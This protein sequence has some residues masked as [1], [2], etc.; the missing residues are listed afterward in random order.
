[1]FLVF[2]AAEGRGD[3]LCSKVGGGNTAP[4]AYGDAVTWPEAAL[5]IDVLANDF[6]ADGDAIKVVGVTGVSGGTA[7][8]TS[9][10]AAVAFTPAPGAAQGSFLYTISDTTNRTASAQVQLLPRGAPPRTVSLSERCVGVDCVLT[11]TLSRTDG[12]R[13]ADF[14]FGD[15]TRTPAGY[16]GTAAHHQYPVVGTYDASVTVTYFSGEVAFVAKSINV[17]PVAETANWTWR[18]VNGLRI[19]AKVTST[20]FGANGGNYQYA[21]YFLWGDDFDW[22]TLLV[23]DSFR[24]VVGTEYY[25]VYRGPR[26]YDV[27]LVVFRCS[28]PPCE[29]G[30]A[31]V[32]D[33]PDNP[34]VITP[35]LIE[36][37]NAEPQADF[38]VTSQ[39]GK[40]FLF[41][42]NPLR[43][44]AAA[45]T[46][47]Y[48]EWDFDDGQTVAQSHPV[49]GQQMETVVHEFDRPGTYFV[50]LQLTDPSAST[51]SAQKAVHVP[52][53]PPTPRIAF[54]CDGGLHCSFDASGSTDDGEVESYR[55]EFSDGTS[56]DGAVA[57]KTFAATGCYQ[58]VLRVVD[59]L[60]AERSAT[61]TVAVSGGAVTTA[62]GLVVDAHARNGLTSN[63]NGI[64]EPGETVVV[65][66][67]WRN[68]AIAQTVATTATALTGPAGP[69]YAILDGTA[70]HG[71]V[72]ANG[73]TDCW[74]TGDCYSVRIDA[75]ASRPAVHWDATLA[76]NGPLGSR[77]TKV[78]VGNSFSDVPPSHPFYRAVES[79]LHHG[80]SSGC[81]AGRY[82][83]DDVVTRGQLAVM[84][85]AAASGTSYTPPACTT[86]PFPDVPCTNPL[87]PWIAEV[88]RRNIASGCNTQGDYCPNAAVTRAQMAVMTLRAREASTYVPP[89]CTAASYGDLPCTHWAAPYVEELRRRGVVSGCAPDRYCPEQTVTRGQAAVFLTGGFGLSIANA[90]C[91]PGAVVSTTGDAAAL[92]GGRP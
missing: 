1:M 62:A 15:G 74:R 66:P 18:V 29:W 41:D 32:I 16:R 8:V 36:V 57:D 91:A 71:T 6:D 56:M 80:I 42:P 30:S 48:L 63:L 92:E 43:D 79:V 5:T 51:G 27:S 85:I 52:N 86:A 7:V 60:D 58:A 37:V 11:A 78:H 83:P 23:N 13:S 19:G 31:T 45:N 40:R 64:A 76:E 12:I 47:Y 77:S 59:D 35:R 25:K 38:T 46:S 54:T 49:N 61:T 55:W 65:E 50:T 33:A 44:D 75:P 89:A 82:C 34:A 10:G 20:T 2:P 90:V 69:S 73:A 81:G 4:V 28:G 17:A 84:L 67:V 72:A 14:V 9:A 3:N 24:G 22:R 87:A 39:G 26:L 68:G 70:Y 53:D 88:K 21:Y